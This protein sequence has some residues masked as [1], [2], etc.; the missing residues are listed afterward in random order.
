MGFSVILFLIYILA[1][2]SS[3]SWKNTRKK[4][5]TP[6]PVCTLSLS[7]GSMHIAH[8]RDLP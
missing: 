6:L 4:K 1:S 8:A 7:Q 2:P 5:E 3:L